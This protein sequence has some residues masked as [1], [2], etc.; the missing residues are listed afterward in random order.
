MAYQRLVL[1]K[2]YKRKKEKQNKINIKN[3]KKV[4]K[5]KIMKKNKLEFI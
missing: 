4:I 2:K 3:N 1:N 5:R